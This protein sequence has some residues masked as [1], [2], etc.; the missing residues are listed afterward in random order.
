M[1]GAGT[2]GSLIAAHLASRAEVS[3]LTRRPEHAAALNADGLRIVG[4]SDLHARVT[5]SD[6]PDLLP[7]FDLAIVAT[8]TTGVEAGD[9][10]ASPAAA[11]ERR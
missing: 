6:D 7:D 11:R 1:L 2:I 4:K 5:A 8:K 3:V 10:G 9:R